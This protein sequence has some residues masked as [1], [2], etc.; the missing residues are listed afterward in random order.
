MLHVQNK[1]RQACTRK[2]LPICAWIGGGHLRAARRGAGP[3]RKMRR[4]LRASYAE[5][6]DRTMSRTGAW[7]TVGGGTP[8]GRIVLQNRGVAR[9]K[10]RELVVCTR[11]FSTDGTRAETLNT[12]QTP[13]L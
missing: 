7:I 13:N 3:E 6:A 8:A 9:R 1:S 10:C 11:Y 12:G 2:F 5:G 4:G